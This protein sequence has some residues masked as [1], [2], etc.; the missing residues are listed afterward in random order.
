MKDASDKLHILFLEDAPADVELV[1]WELEQSGM[2]FELR[3]VQTRQAFLRELQRHPPDVILS[4]RGLPQ[5]NGFAALA[6]AREKRPETPFIFVTGSLG[7]DV[8]VQA[9]E[10]GADDV[11][12]KHRL[13]ALVPTVRRVLG[14]APD[15]ALHRPDG[16][17][18]HQ[19]LVMQAARDAIVL[20]D[21]RGLV[22][23]WN[24]AAER[25]FGHPRA[26]AVGKELTELI[27]PPAQRDAQRRTLLRHLRATGPRRTSHRMELTAR[28]ADGLEFP[29]ELVIALDPAVQPPVLVGFLRDI[30]HRKHSE[31]ALRNS[32]HQY[33]FLL[34]SVTD[35]ALFML[36][37]EGR[38]RTWNAGA[39]RLLGS[40]ARS[41]MGRPLATFFPAEDHRHRR[42]ER[43][44]ARAAAEGRSKNESWCVRRD[45]SRFFAEWTFTAVRDSAGRLAGFTALARDITELRRA[46]EALQHSEERYRRL[47]ELSPIAVMLHRNERII[48]CNAAALRLL[49]GQSAQELLGR[50]VLE[51]VSAKDRGKITERLRQLREGRTVPFLEETLVRLDGSTVEAEVAATPVLLPE[52]PQTPAVLLVAVDITERKRAERALRESEDR[53]R[54]AVEA[55][56]DYGIYMLDPEGRV[57]SWNAGAERMAGYRT[58]EI[59]GRSCAVFFT[60]EDIQRGAPGQELKTAAEKGVARGE[61]WAVRKDGTRFL[62]EWVLTAVREPDGRLT[63]FS[64]VIH[65]ITERRRAEEEIARLYAE[66]EQRVTQRTAQLEAANQELEAFSYS[67]SHDLRAPLRHIEGFIDLLQQS[68]AGALDATSREHLRVITEAAHHMSRLIDALLS[69]SRMSRVP[70]R[71]VRVSLKNLVAAVRHDLRYDV[72]GRKIEWVIGELPEVLGDAS[73]LRQVL[74][75]L[76]SNALKYTR[77]RAVARIELGARSN[78]G[79]IVFF[80][81]DNGIGFDMQYAGKLFGVFQRLHGMAEFEGTGIGLAIVRRIIQRHGGRVWAEGQPDAGATFYFALPKN[82]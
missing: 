67:V 44:L 58:E 21:S 12:F 8:A 77:M 3:P 26:E 71:K 14:S 48:F 35:Y 62:A 20:L 36:D 72:E 69:F 80:V 38:V 42:L 7:E 1:R 64:G 57:V 5:F 30:T 50:S 51:F 46:R 10:R 73:L 4:D 2:A 32:E 23:D 56:E 61:S 70:L 45:G 41:I 11:V 22:Q 19:A 53:F 29:V 59:I 65:D 74:F 9:F 25:L 6:V 31:V 34:E 33:R 82:E 13:A 43:D 63:G 40:P 79:E 81:R 24:P 47:V 68:A 54:M 27:V 37:P 28:R 76:L 18:W 15:R 55:V 17:T 78:N 39:E 52:D 66:M 60:P 16:A 75:N 49:Q